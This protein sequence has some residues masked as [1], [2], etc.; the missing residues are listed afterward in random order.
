MRLLLLPLAVSLVF[1]PAAPAF[2]GDACVSGTITAEESNDPGFEGYYKYTIELS[3]DVTGF[4]V[5]SH[6]DLFLDLGVCDC[7]CDADVFEFPSPAGTSDGLDAQGAPCVVSY[8]GSFACMG[9]PSLPKDDRPAVKF[10]AATAPECEPGETGSATFCFYSLFPPFGDET[11]ISSAGVK[12]GPDFCEGTLM[13]P[14]PD[15]ECAVSVDPSSWSR[16][17]GQYR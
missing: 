11:T 9:D 14:V 1:T 8:D 15:C 5:P 2:A 10:D 6:F 16:I 4:A 7:I 13:G 3:W 12:H 17:K